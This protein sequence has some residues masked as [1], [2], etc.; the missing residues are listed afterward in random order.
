MKYIQYDEAVKKIGDIMSKLDDTNALLVWG[1]VS[2]MWC[3]NENEI[4]NKLVDE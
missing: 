4:I 2:D 1:A 3:E